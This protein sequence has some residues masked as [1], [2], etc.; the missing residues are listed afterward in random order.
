MFWYCCVLLSE[1]LGMV[2]VVGVL[3]V[4]LPSFKIALTSLKRVKSCCGHSIHKLT[5]SLTSSCW[6]ASIFLYGCPFVMKIASLH[7]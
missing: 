5:F 7:R 2:W 1:Y 6:H 3:Y 4:A